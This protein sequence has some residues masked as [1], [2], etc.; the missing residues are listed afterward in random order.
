MD[1]SICIIRMVEEIAKKEAEKEVLETRDAN[2]ETNKTR[3]DKYKDL[4]L[5]GE[6]IKEAYHIG[7]LIFK[8][9][10]VLFTNKRL[11][12]I[13]KIPKNVIELDYKDIEL[14]EFYTNI[15]WLKMFYALL[16]YVLLYQIF[17]NIDILL[18]KIVEFIPPLEP[19]LYAGDFF[20]MNMGAFFP[21]AILFIAG[22]YFAGL[23]VLS[24]I[25]RLRI[26]VYDQPPFD[27]ATLYDKK[28]TKLI[29]TFSELSEEYREQREERHP[30][31]QQKQ[32][33]KMESSQ[34]P[35]SSRNAGKKPVQSNKPD[36]VKETSEK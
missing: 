10:I 30:S 24:A 6:H 13:K 32:A 9:Y 23:F 33:K 22:T 19:L 17:I 15:E 2:K 5:E 7:F 29:H 35:E 28:V 26:L 27:I 21:S 31:T 14:V 8:L 4:L 3:Y 18:E 16:L 25:G 11:I 20:G 36:V 34:D 1:S 12:L